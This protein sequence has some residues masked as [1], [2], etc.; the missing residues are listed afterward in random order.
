VQNSPPFD[1]MRREVV[2][3]WRARPAGRAPQA[4]SR[5]P[6][7]V[8]PARRRQ[9]SARPITITRWP[10]TLRYVAY[11]A[12]HGAGDCSAVRGARGS[13]CGRRSRSFAA[14]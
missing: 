9:S 1:R 13:A 8:Q 7:V 11:V 6:R 4:L 14:T 3:V 10:S 5:V 12:R 2:V